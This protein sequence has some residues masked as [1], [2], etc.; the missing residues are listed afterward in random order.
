MVFSYI[1]DTLYKD[2]DSKNQCR[3]YYISD[4]KSDLE[5]YGNVYIKIGIKNRFEINNDSPITAV[6]RLI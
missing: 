4:I 3:Y 6:K 1:D 2:D 5:W